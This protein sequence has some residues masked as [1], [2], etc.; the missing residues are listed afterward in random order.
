MAFNDCINDNS[1]ECFKNYI[2]FFTNALEWK[3]KAQRA[4]YDIAFNI[5][6]KINTPDS[7]KK[8]INDFNSF[9]LI[10][11]YFQSDDL[12]KISLEKC[13]RIRIRKVKRT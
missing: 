11:N 9:K 4:I 10:D 13:L 5:A 2:S 3:I 1:I 8:F 7:Y 6:E 12:L